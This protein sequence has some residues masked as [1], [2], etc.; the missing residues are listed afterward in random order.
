MTGLSSDGPKPSKNREFLN[1]AASQHFQM[2][3]GDFFRF[4]DM[5]K[6]Q[7][8][9]GIVKELLDSG[10]MSN[11]QFKMLQQKASGFINLLRMLK[12]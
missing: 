9:N 1:K 2:N 3:V 12:K 7:D 5:A 11:D 6:G 8:V 10:E 4:A